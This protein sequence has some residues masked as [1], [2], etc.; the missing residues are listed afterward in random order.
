MD[1][2]VQLTPGASNPPSLPSRNQ[3]LWSPLRRVLDRC[4]LAKMHKKGRS[5]RTIQTFVHETNKYLADWLERP[6]SELTGEKL[7]ELH[8][9]IKDN[10]HGDYLYPEVAELGGFVVAGPCAIDEIVRHFGAG[11]YRVTGYGSHVRRSEWTPS[12]RIDERRYHLR[13]NVAGRAFGGR[14]AGRWLG[15]AAERPTLIRFVS[16]VRPVVGLR[17]NRAGSCSRHRALDRVG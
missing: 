15:V 2:A 7:A 6:F 9:Q 11:A 16:N 14:R 3:P 4:C 17:F 1:G 12:D 13:R 8:Q 10:Q 5:P